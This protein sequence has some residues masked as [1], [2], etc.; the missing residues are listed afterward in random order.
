[1]RALTERLRCR[2]LRWR[3]VPVPDLAIALVDVTH[4]ARPV[5][6]S[7]WL[8]P[9]PNF[10]RG[11]LLCHL[12]PCWREQPRLVARWCR[13]LHQPG[14]HLILPP[15][16][17]FHLMKELFFI[18]GEGTPIHSVREDFLFLHGSEH[19]ASTA[20]IVLVGVISLA[21]PIDLLD[22]LRWG[23]SI[24]LVLSFGR[25][26]PFLFSRY[27]SVDCWI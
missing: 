9:T 14:R 15:F 5:L 13:L 12:P 6:S 10:C 7:R 18:P 1:M 3:F 19:D 2:H 16:N 26:L 24:V 8:P 21:L 11:G 22:G 20:Q 25:F 17:P 27:F 23:R 4:L